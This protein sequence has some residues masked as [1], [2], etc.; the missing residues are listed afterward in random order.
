MFIDRNCSHRHIHCGNKQGSIQMKSFGW[1]HLAT[2]A[3]MTRRLTL[4]LHKWSPS[5]PFL[6]N[7]I[8]T[9]STLKYTQK[10]LET[11]NNL[12]HHWI[13]WASSAIFYE[14]SS[15]V[16]LVK[17]LRPNSDICCI[18]QCFFMNIHLKLFQRISAIS[19]WWQD[20]FLLEAF[21]YFFVKLTSLLH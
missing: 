20:C 4:A 13:W 10:H 11:K 14:L 8:F 9:W 1:K 7:N 16:L 5:W 18:H 21:V 15:S 19:W 17:R 6:E 3:Y 12:L 2:Q